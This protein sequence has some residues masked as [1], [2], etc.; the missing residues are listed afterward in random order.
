M[1]NECGP[2]VFQV[3]ETGGDRLVIRMFDANQIS[4]SVKELTESYSG[5]LEAQIAEESV[6]A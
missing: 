4:V 5:A 1:A 3:G 6:K 2:D